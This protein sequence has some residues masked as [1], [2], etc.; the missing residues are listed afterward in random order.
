MLDTTQG[1]PA[2]RAWAG[3]LIAT[4][5][6]LPGSFFAFVFGG[7]AP[8]ACDNCDGAEAERFTRGFNTAHTV[9]HGGLTAAFVILLVSW[10]LP[11]NE[12]NV[13]PRWVL[14]ALA[15]GTVVLSVLVFASM[16]PW[17]S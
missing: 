14:A 9:L 16:V 6:T 13:V 1:G 5:L 3:P 17:P 10:C 15:P 2:R 4:V 12:R 7:L 8:M 11:W